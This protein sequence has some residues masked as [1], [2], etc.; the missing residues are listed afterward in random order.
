MR[1]RVHLWGKASRAHK[2]WS[3]RINIIWNEVDAAV[4]LLKWDIILSQ[5]LDSSLRQ[6][7]TGFVHLH[8]AKD[9][10][11]TNADESGGNNRQHGS[12]QSH[13]H[14]VRTIP[15]SRHREANQCRGDRDV[16][17]GEAGG[18]ICYIGSVSA[19]LTCAQ[20]RSVRTT[21]HGG[22]PSPRIRHLL[23]LLNQLG[24]HACNFNV[25]YGMEDGWNE[26]VHCWQS[27]MATAVSFL[28]RQLLSS[29]HP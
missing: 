10:D 27:R 18:G 28:Q 15:V 6:V 20:R 8:A 23:V 11:P 1:W 4:E 3:Q 26:F 22:R 7:Q 17:G 2:Q 13:T 24:I 12:R 14:S 9:R 5:K 29:P 21:E 19:S 16:C 25:I